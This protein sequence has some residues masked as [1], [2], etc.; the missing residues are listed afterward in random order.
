MKTIE[1][2][3]HARLLELLRSP[4]FPTLQSLADCLERS[5]TQVSQ[6]KNQSKRSGGG[7]CNIDSDS[8]RHI[9]TRT[10]RPVGWMDNDPAHDV[11]TAST[12]GMTVAGWL[13]DLPEAKRMKAFWIIHQMVFADQWPEPATPAQPPRGLPSAEPTPEPAPSANR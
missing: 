7:R 2:I 11:R 13:D 4:D 6:W 8:A 5:P 9:E 12:M 3:R 10:G 1:D